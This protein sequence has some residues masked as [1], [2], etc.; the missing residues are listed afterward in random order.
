MPESTTIWSD[1][2][3]RDKLAELAKVYERSSAAQLR[4]IIKREY[5]KAVSDGILND[6]DQEEMEEEDAVSL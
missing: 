6:Q 1:T 3:T 4:F 5:A 2:E